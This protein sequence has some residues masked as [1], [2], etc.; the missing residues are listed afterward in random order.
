MEV[1]FKSGESTKQ[2]IYQMMGKA[3]EKKSEEVE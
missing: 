2:N 3:I 1:I